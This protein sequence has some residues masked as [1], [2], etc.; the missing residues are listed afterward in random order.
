LLGIDWG[1]NMNGVINLKQR[2]MIFKKKLHRVV[3]PLDPIEGSR[4]IE[5]TRSQ[6]R[7]DILDSIYQHAATEE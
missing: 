6:E 5:P 4:Y 7:G 2:K 1:T 3:V